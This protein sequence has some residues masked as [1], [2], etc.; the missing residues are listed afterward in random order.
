LLTSLE[1]YSIGFEIHQG[2][3]FIPILEKFQKKFNIEKQIVVADS[4]LLSKKNIELLEANNYKYVLG[5][6]IKSVSNIIKDKILNLKL[7]PLIKH[8][9]FRTNLIK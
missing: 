2:N 7:S 8:S 1:G 3:T 5:A 6:R 4:G 9:N